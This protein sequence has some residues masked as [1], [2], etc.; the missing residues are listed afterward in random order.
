MPPI[1]HSNLRH[2]IEKGEGNGQCVTKSDIRIEMYIF[3]RKFYLLNSF[4][5]LCL[6]KGKFGTVFL[7]KI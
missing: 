7:T 1:D 3:S 4:D 2:M 5:Q 6:R